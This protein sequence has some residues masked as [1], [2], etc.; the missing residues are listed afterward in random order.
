MFNRKETS[1]A[2]TGKQQHSPQLYYR[3]LQEDIG[4][5]SNNWN[6]PKQSDNEAQGRM[7]VGRR[8]DVPTVVPQKP[9]IKVKTSKSTGKETINKK[10]SSQPV[11]VE[12]TSSRYD[13]YG[14]SA[15]QYNKPIKGGPCC[16]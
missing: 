4:R 15:Y 13:S 9:P 12:G 2:R 6:R 10:G 7:E 11:A 3:P 14:L 1:I 8:A 16:C 5:G